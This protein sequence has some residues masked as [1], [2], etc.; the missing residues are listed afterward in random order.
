MNRD[1]SNIFAT[2]SEYLDQELPEGDC[3]E[4]EKHI[5][6]CAPCVAFVDSL[7]KSVAAGKGFR[8]SGEEA[9]ELKPEVK[10]SLRDAYEKMLAERKK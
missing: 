8:P 10:Q 9:P 6:E 3:A 2:L 1:C 7:K 5:Q 4:L